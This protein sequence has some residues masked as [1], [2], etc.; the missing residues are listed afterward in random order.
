[1]ESPYKDGMTPPNPYK[2]AVGTLGILAGVIHWFAV[3]HEL[4]WRVPGTFGR[5]YIGPGAAITAVG[6]FP[7]FI[8]L[9]GQRTAMPPDTWGYRLWL[10]QL[11]LMMFQGACT[12]IN[13]TRRHSQYIG[14][15][16]FSFLGDA[17]WAGEAVCSLALSAALM[18]LSANFGI[19]LLLVTVAGTLHI[20]LIHLRQV[21]MAQNAYDAQSEAQIF[22]EDFR[23]WRR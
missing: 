12:Q 9:T 19:Y 8:E 18:P 3:Q 5:R 16:W 14:R 11:G 13:L 7:L 10:A 23:S 6:G 2:G 15:S 21:R 1:M 20:G 22:R 17:F 4:L